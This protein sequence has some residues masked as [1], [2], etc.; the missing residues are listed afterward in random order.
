M[1]QSYYIFLFIDDGQLCLYSIMWKTILA[2]GIYLMSVVIFSVFS[3]DKNVH[4]IQ[5][6]SVFDLLHASSSVSA[7]SVGL[8]ILTEE[9]SLACSVIVCYV[10]HISL[11]SVMEGSWG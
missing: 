10:S 9:F 4:D 7:F 6:W 3:D 2:A 8:P 11:R 1:K 5:K